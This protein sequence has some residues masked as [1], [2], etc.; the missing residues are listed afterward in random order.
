[1][2]LQ[3]FRLIVERSIMIRT[4]GLHNSNPRNIRSRRLVRAMPLL[5]LNIVPSWTL[6]V[7]IAFSLCDGNPGDSSCGSG[8]VTIV[9]LLRWF[10]MS[11][12]SLPSVKGASLAVFYCGF[13][14]CIRPFSGSW[15]FWIQVAGVRIPSVSSYRSIYVHVCLIDN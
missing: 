12:K 2:F 9:P 13:R 1:M 5:L 10:V 15:V 11:E 4:V 14:S 6:P 8:R 3:F 7:G